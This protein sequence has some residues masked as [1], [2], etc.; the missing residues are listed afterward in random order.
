VS[1]VLS[2]YDYVHPSDAIYVFGPDHR[3]LTWEEIA[4]ENPDVVYIPVPPGSA[5]REMFSYTAAAI[6][7]YDRIKKE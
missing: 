2:L 7:A 5:M 1:G 4:L 3:N 6:V